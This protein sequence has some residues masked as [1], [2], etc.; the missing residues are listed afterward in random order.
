MMTMMII[1]WATCLPSKLPLPVGDL[2]PNLIQHS[3]MLH[4]S[5]PS[6]IISIGLSVFAQVARVPNTYRH[7]PRYFATFVAIGHIDS[8]RA[9]DTACLESDDK[10]H[11]AEL[12]SKACLLVA[13]F[14]LHANKMY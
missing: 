8:Q 2:Y 13:C 1:Q 10:A 11:L 12:P 9:G 14:D 3:F 5:T 7:R 6:N 4:E